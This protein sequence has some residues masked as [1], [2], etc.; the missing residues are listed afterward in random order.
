[1]AFMSY[2]CG[3]VLPHPAVGDAQDWMGLQGAVY[4]KLG[5]SACGPPVSEAGGVEGNPAPRQHRLSHLDRLRESVMISPM[6]QLLTHWIPGVSCDGWA[7]AAPRLTSGTRLAAVQD[8]EGGSGQAHVPV[9]HRPLEPR[10]IDLIIADERGYAVAVHEVVIRP[11]PF[12]VDRYVRVAGVEGEIITRTFSFRSLGTRAAL[13]EGMIRA[14]TDSAMSR[15]VISTSDALVVPRIVLQDTS[16]IGQVAHQIHSSDSTMMLDVRVT[17]QPRYASGEATTSL[18]ASHADPSRVAVDMASDVS[19]TPSLMLRVH[20]GKAMRREVVY[21]V[22]YASPLRVTPL[23]IWRLDIDAHQR[24]DMNA[25]LRTVSACT[26]SVTPESVVASRP[27]YSMRAEEAAVAPA[28]SDELVVADDGRA[29][30]SHHGYG[31]GVSDPVP[32]YSTA[33][34]GR[35]NVVSTIPGRGGGSAATAS[36]GD[37]GG[38]AHGAQLS[39]AGVD[40][41]LHMLVSVTTAS[42]AVVRTDM[43]RPF[44]LVRAAATRQARQGRMR[45]L[46]GGEDGEDGAAFAA[47][48]QFK[49]L[50]KPHLTGELR[51]PLHLVLND[52]SEDGVAWQARMQEEARLLSV[53]HGRDGDYWDDGV[54]PVPPAASPLVAAKTLALRRLL[55]PSTTLLASWMIV[56]HTQL[57]TVTGRCASMRIPRANEVPA[58]R[59]RRSP[60]VCRKRVMFMNQ[61]A[62]DQRYVV[63]VDRPDMVVVGRPRVV[64]AGKL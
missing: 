11:L 22:I 37:R 6:G 59:L 52:A 10:T 43:V 57:P 61:R 1:M 62:T 41:G 35:G 13:R 40:D 55:R 38:G 18:R 2:D 25:Q 4:D 42:S 56:A 44:Y 17:E 54:E 45:V 27:G 63:T 29:L 33:L 30:H 53:I 46:A 20:V 23:E 16:K 64:V 28:Y 31:S 60:F 50:V 32:R 3:D 48:N 26:V 8:G 19:L 24:L 51:V 5:M 47:T 58:E 34:Q 49:V 7:L 9:V 39:T 14:G 15:M 36:A 21:V 12:I